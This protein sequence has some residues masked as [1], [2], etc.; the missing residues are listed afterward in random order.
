MQRSELSA[1]CTR[2]LDLV[3]ASE[4]PTSVSQLSK[5]SGTHGN[6]VREHLD[7]LRKRGFVVRESSRSASRGRPAWLYRAA[8][9]SGH[10]GVEYA[11]LAS[12]L[13]DQ[14]E[15][16]S[17]HPHEAAVE[18]GERWGEALAGPPTHEDGIRRQVI[19]MLDELGFDPDPEPVGG[20]VRLRS[21]PMIDAATQHPEV[22]CR[23]HLGMVRGIVKNVGG[24]PD[25]AEMLAFYEPDACHVGVGDVAV[26]DRVGPAAHS[27]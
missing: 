8:R 10:H 2:I 19:S 11:G 14:L 27:R 7:A 25:T 23:V 9:G 17:D 24:D 16:S 5:Q 21:C 26:D 4:G 12:V 18:A 20:R 3:L 15:R 1:A 6:T 13:A 22:V